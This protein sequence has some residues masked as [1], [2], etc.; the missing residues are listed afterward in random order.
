MTSNVAIV[1]QNTE[2]ARAI[3]DAILADNP[4]ASASRYPAMVKIDCPGELIVNR[5]S[6]SSRLGREF[7]LQEMH[8][9]LVNIS[10]NI[11]EDD[12]RL[13]LSWQR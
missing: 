1:L 3:I 12:D 5:D 2:D 8:L 7:D 11:D 4:A 9:N 13:V 10:G 6:V